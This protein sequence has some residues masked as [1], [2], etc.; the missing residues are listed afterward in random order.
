MGRFSL[1]RRSLKLP[2]IIV[3][4]GALCKKRQTLRF[5]SAKGLDAL[6]AYYL[7]E[8]ALYKRARG[9]NESNRRVS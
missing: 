3:P 5:K 4:I 2:R 7:Y 8:R 9:Q 1:S 6:C